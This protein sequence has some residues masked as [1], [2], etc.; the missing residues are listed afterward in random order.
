LGAGFHGKLVLYGNAEKMPKSSLG[1]ASC[2]AVATE[3]NRQPPKLSS[4]LYDPASPN[5]AE[6]ATFKTLWLVPTI[7]AAFGLPFLAAGLI[8]L[9]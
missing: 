8:G 3:L 4:V 2:R 1:A 9:L 6:L 7:M 5:E